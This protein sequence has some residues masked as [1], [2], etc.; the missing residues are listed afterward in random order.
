[1]NGCRICT[2][3]TWFAAKDDRGRSERFE[4][5]GTAYWHTEHRNTGE[6]LPSKQGLKLKDYAPGK[7]AR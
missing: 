4:G 6:N 2:I 1:M 7:R 3:F 5:V